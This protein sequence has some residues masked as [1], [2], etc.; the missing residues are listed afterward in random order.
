MHR[1]TNLNRKLHCSVAH[2]TGVSCGAGEVAGR[3]RFGVLFLT[4]VLAVSALSVRQ[5]VLLRDVA[6][7]A[8]ISAARQQRMIVRLPAR[9]GSIYARSSRRYVPLALSRQSPSCFVDPSLLSDD[10]LDEVAIAAG[11]VL[12]ID[13]REIQK[14]LFQRRQKQYVLLQRGLTNQ[15]AEAIRK[16]RIPALGITHEWTREYPNEDLAATVLGFRRI[17]GVGAGG[18]ELSQ[19]EALS[20]TDGRRVLR[21]DAFKRPIWPIAEQ[22]IPPLDG[23]NV[24][25]TIDAVVQDALATAV[26]D[27]VEEFD[28]KWG[29]GIVVNPQTG[30][31]LAMCSAPTFN[32]NEYSTADPNNITNR[33]ITVPFEPGSVF[34]PLIAAAAVEAGKIDYQTQIFCED[35]TYR[36]HRGGRISDHGEKYGY[37]TVADGV[38]FSSNICMAKIGEIVGNDFLHAA[39]VNFGFGQRTGIDLPGESRGIVR[40]LAKWDGYSLRRV[41]FGQEIST[42]AMQLVMAFSSIANGGL[43]LKPRLI[44]KVTDAEGNIVYQSERNVVRRV[45]SP[46]VADQSLDVLAAVVERGT[47][48]ACRLANWRSFGKTGTAQIAGVGGYVENAFVGSFVGGAPVD[49][50]KLICLIS[51]YWPDK[52]KGHYGSEVAAPYVRDVLSKSLRYMNVPSDMPDE[53]DD[54]LARMR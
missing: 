4:V 51:I 47:G 6:D 15:Q 19:D 5:L 50:P 8:A 12:G 16:L 17:D 48:K 46:P 41:P 14:K 33:A 2:P 20:A 53:S 9:P 11:D 31:I 23:A 40:P 39:A 44:D 26:A 36:A 32:P 52:S 27:S 43:L 10:Q 29:T 3:W 7:E 30:E 42:T 18:L 34:K 21:A 22:S 13:A 35:G 1:V 38:V 28:A 25:L 45:L 37:L 49:N 54:Q 24:F